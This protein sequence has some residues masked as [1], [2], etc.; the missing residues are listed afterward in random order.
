MRDRQALRVGLVGCGSHGNALAQAIARTDCLRLVACAD[1]DQPAASRAAAFGDAVST[2]DTV[3]SLL[4]E[5]DVDAV[6]IATPHHFLGPAAMSA[7]R[8]GKHVLAEK[9][10]ALNEPE[11]KEV[12]LAATRAGVSY[13]AGYSFRFSMASYVHDLLVAGVAGEIQAITGSIGTGPMNRGW[14]AYP[15]TG[16]GPLLDV[17][18]HLIDLILWFLA[19]EPVGVYADVRRRA[20]TGADESSAIQLRFS[21]GALAQCLVTQATSAFSYGIDLHG[22]T[23]KVALRGRNLLQFE[24]EVSSTS[25]ATYREPTTIRPTVRRDKISTMLVPE[26]EEFARSVRERRPPAVT[27]SDGRRV[28]GVL[29][30]IVESGR[31]G[32]TAIPGR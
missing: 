8:A 18:C 6:V 14:L 4:A 25:V 23:G 5:S 13:M 17:G 15:E 12:E 10:M 27:A 16:G 20:D 28:L 21:R 19:D 1:P 9:P 26:L 22:R 29:D 32:R 24:I 30:A 11:A 31:S 7:L 2:H 3:D